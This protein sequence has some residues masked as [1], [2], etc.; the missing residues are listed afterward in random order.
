MREWKEQQSC[1]NIQLCCRIQ[2]HELQSLSQRNNV[3]T[4]RLLTKK[5]IK[6]IEEILGCSQNKLI[7]YVLQD[8][9]CGA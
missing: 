8:G 4:T 7:D 5:R 1:T 3:E 2:Y 9:L 6:I